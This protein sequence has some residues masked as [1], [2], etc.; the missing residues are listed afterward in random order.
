VAEVGVP[1][2]VRVVLV[3]D[4]DVV[5]IGLRGRLQGPDVGGVVEVVGSAGSVEGMRAVL[6]RRRC[7]VVV[8]DLAL[9]DGSDPAATVRW[10]VDQ[11]VRVLI[12]SI[13]DDAA[14]LRQVLASGASGLSRKSEP[15]EETVAKIL[16]VAQGQDVVSPEVL[17]LIDGDAAFTQARLSDREREVLV[18]YVSGLDVAQ[19]GRRL[20]LTE[21]SVKE[22]L[23]RV[24]SKYS[25]VDRPANNRVDLLRRAIEDGIVPPIQPH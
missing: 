9:D 11:D 4:H 23:R 3:D 15:I 5:R 21:N 1:R 6:A 25:G 14:V 17:A 16:L 12:Y 19:I 7:D 22:Y 24:R 13:A 2:P 10:L 18:L 20:Y 8:L